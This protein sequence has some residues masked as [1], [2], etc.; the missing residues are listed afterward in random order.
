MPTLED[1]LMIH[2]EVCKDARELVKS[3]GADYNRE[4]Q[5]NGNTLFN[6]LVCSILGI[7]AS[8]TQGLLV[9]LSDKF[10]RLISLTKDPNVEAEVKNESVRDTVIDM[11]NYTI[12][13]YILWKEARNE[14]QKNMRSL[15]QS[16]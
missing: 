11:I 14:H 3:K 2:E 15:P 8:A 1:V 5:V 16:D 6:L 4:Q 10:M 13:L 9:R 12:Y 7:V